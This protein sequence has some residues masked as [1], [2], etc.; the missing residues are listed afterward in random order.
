MLEANIEE[1]QRLVRLYERK[2]GRVSGVHFQQVQAGNTSSQKDVSLRIVAREFGRTRDQVRE[3]LTRAGIETRTYFDPPVHLQAAYAAW[4][5]T[6]GRLAVTEQVAS[7]ILN[8]PLFVGL[9][10]TDVERVC[11]TIRSCTR[12]TVEV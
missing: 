7:E 10:E 8:V 2:L 4:R 11:D 6:T 9:T 1:R 5:K 3:E 12:K